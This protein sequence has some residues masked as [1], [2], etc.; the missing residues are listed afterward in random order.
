MGIFRPMGIV[1]VAND[2]EDCFSNPCLI[3]NGGCEEYC[4]LNTSGHVECACYK[5]RTL[6]GDGRCF[7]VSATECANTEDR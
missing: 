4:Q 7:S 2:T 5:G 3:N 1:A 6:S